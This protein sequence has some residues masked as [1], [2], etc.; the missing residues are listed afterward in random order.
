MSLQCVILSLN[1]WVGRLDSVKLLSIED[2]TLI[3]PS[4][5]TSPPIQVV[6]GEFNPKTYHLHEDLVCQ[7][8]ASL[9]A[10]FADQDSQEALERRVVL[11]YED[12]DLFALFIEWLYSEEMASIAFSDVKDP[13][14]YLI[15]AR[16]YL[17]G[18]RLEAR[19]FQHVIC[20]GIT[21]TF[22]RRYIPC[23]L[24]F[25]A[26]TELAGLPDGDPL[27]QQIFY[28]AE[29]CASVSDRSPAF[30]GIRRILQRQPLRRAQAPRTTVPSAPRNT[31]HGQSEQAAHTPESSGRE[32]WD[33]EQ[34]MT[35]LMAREK[36][37]AFN[38]IVTEY[39]PHRTAKA[40]KRR[41]E[42]LKEWERGTKAPVHSS[43]VYTSGRAKKRLVNTP[44]QY[45]TPIRLPD[46]PNPHVTISTPPPPDPS[47]SA[48]TA[49]QG[50]QFMG[51]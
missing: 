44:E 23:E 15:L 41:Y 27:R 25:V 10:I 35:L 16:L 9:A 17:M 14:Q 38:D 47:Q 30:D 21:S 31:E 45:S 33:P 49:A 4:W 12:P 28:H 34:D 29:R 48:S 46:V 8:S 1:K 6:V 19:R 7:A 32:R 22:G 50:L 20:K 24:L 36:G 37:I 26:H 43:V 2:S 13:S 18:Q 42:K 5:L 11:Q 3:V 51:P 39:F 40:C